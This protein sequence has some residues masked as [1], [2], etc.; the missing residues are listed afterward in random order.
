[1]R[2]KR[3]I[4]MVFCSVLML[5][6]LPMAGFGEDVVTW[7]LE[8]GE[9]SILG[10]GEMRFSTFPWADRLEDIR[11]IRLDEHITS[12]QDGAFAGCTELNSVIL[13][14]DLRY[15]GRE[16][17]R[18]C[19]S[20][21]WITLPGGLVGIGEEAFADCPN[22]RCVSIPKSVSRIGDRGFEPVILLIGWKDSACD[23]YIKDNGGN[24]SQTD[25]YTFSDASGRW[26]DLSWK[27]ENGKMTITGTGEI[28]GERLE[29][30]PWDAYRGDITSL[31]IGS[32]ITA[33]DSLAFAQC[34][35]LTRVTLPE[36][37][38]EIGDGSFRSDATICGVADSLAQTYANVNNLPFLSVTEKDA[39]VQPPAQEETAPVEDAKAPIKT[40]EPAVPEPE[41]TASETTGEPEKGTEQAEEP[42]GGEPEE[43]IAE[44]P[45]EAE[46]VPEGAEKEEP[47]PQNGVL[48]LDSVSAQPGQQIAV[49]VRISGNPGL[50]GMSFAIDYDNTVL[51]LADY[52]CT[53]DILR[54]GD[55]TVGIGEGEKALWLQ[56]DP[57]EEDGE[58][59]TL[60]FRVAEGAD[61][62]EYTVELAD[63][64]AV[65]EKANAVSLTVQP[66]TVTLVSGVP[67]DV[68]GDGRVT[69]GDAKRLRR[70][71]AGQAIAIENGNAD[72]NGDGTVNIID[73]MLLNQLVE[74]E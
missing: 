43:T 46:K 68:N 22:L 66:G 67:G 26:N 48:T 71:L 27:L 14:Q 60:L 25:Y 39:D 41:E 4:T 64:L 57:T 49:P 13:S 55:W 8:G 12:I 33:L 61:Q 69:T 1:M 2:F 52:D 28:R 24:F 35:K 45:E 5:W 38:V 65:D 15:I 18:G 54:T 9:L 56:S 72:L 58:L 47:A 16:A 62:G 36:S 11:Y 29:D 31:E 50:C 20:L 40:E 63:V 10:A 53:G 23:D 32:G 17:F 73:L 19:T 21:S 7:S 59:L 37:V 3:L 70:Y 6:A 34:R 44:T 30:Y 42:T 51:T 74:K